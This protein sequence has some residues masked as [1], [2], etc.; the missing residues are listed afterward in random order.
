LK[1]QSF[2][3]V[4]RQMEYEKW[5]NENATLRRIKKNVPGNVGIAPIALAQFLSW[6]ALRGRENR[7]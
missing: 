1:K 2:G 6:L 7:T 5:K 4:S 3:K